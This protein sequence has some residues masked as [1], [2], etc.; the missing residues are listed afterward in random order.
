MKVESE[1][2]EIFSPP[3]FSGRS[4]K[5]VIFFMIQPPDTAE[6][7]YNAR[8]FE[9]LRIALHEWGNEFASLNL[10]HLRKVKSVSK[11]KK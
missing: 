7:C 1:K 8:R 5:G 2:I 9:G 4:F 6:I 3:T 10:H 11:A